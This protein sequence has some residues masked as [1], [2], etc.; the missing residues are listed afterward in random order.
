M[1]QVPP[2]RQP[3]PNRLLASSRMSCAIS[4]F[5]LLGCA[6]TP[7]GT[8]DPEGPPPS[9]GAV[10][11]SPRPSWAPPLDR[12][13]PPF[14]ARAPIFLP[15]Q[16]TA[17]FISPAGTQTLF[18]RV[19]IAGDDP[20]ALKREG[21][22][23]LSFNPAYERLVLH[24]LTIW[25]NGK[26]IDQSKSVVPRLLTAD[27]AN[28]AVYGGSV[29]ALYELSDFRPGDQLELAWSVTGSNPVFELNHFGVIEWAKPFPVW[30]RTV[31]ISMPSDAKLSVDVV[32]KDRR[33]RPPATGAIRRTEQLSAGQRQIT[34]TQD[35]VAPVNVEQRAAKGSIQNTLISYSAFKDWDAVRAWAQRLFEGVPPPSSQAYQTLV[36]DVR[37]KAT[38]AER[39]S[40]ALRWVQREIRY[41]SMSVGQNSH[42]PHPPDEVLANRYGDCKDTALLLTRVL[43]DAGIDAA[44][45]LVLRGN[46]RLTPRLNAVP[47]FDHAVVVAW[48][49]GTPHVLDATLS[50]QPS[51]LG[52]QGVRY[53]WD[54]L[55]VLTG[56]KAGFV[57]IPLPPA[58]EERQ[59]VQTETMT[60]HDLDGPGVLTIHVALAGVRAEIQR[61]QARSRSRED[62]KREFLQQLRTLHPRAQWQDEPKY[63]DNEAENRV[64]MEGR[65][66]IP[67][68][69]K[70]SPGGAWRYKY[71][72]NLVTDVLA[73]PIDGARETSMGLTV[74]PRRVTLTHKLILP[75]GSKILEPKYDE[76]VRSP[77]LSA[78]LRRERPAPNVFVDTTDVATTA[79]LVPPEDIDTYNAAARRVIDI[80]TSVQVRP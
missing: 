10:L 76:S 22:Q 7:V 63:V 80:D 50:E 27:N 8:S 52:R 11:Q 59:V 29:T 6:H 62:L 75:S 47:L 28:S 60:V 13:D 43:R 39:A 37:A 26:A 55:F 51:R 1:I 69:L 48:I 66:V 36:H 73:P 41:V 12:S 16:D 2:H 17:V 65:F 25:R 9:F 38:P 3:V 40:D 20:E 64:E 32:A 23:A 15:A 49:D 72:H 67:E 71:R 44:P 70:R 19:V 14:G 61:Q 18:H 24:T 56:E 5:A 54:Q 78:R 57:E 45:A 42:R 68:P 4:L 21:R 34:F 79:I 35:H 46:S 74:D 53:G 33:G 31:S 30:R 58:T 77:Y